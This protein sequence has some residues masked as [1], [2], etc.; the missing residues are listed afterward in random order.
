M[1]ST[2][3]AQQK[4]MCM[5][6]A[7]R[8]GKLNKSELKGAALDI[9]NSDMTDKEIKDFMVLKESTNMTL[10]ES[11]LKSVKAGKYA[12]IDDWCKNNITN[13]NGYII[14]DD[15]TISDK[16]GAGIY[17]KNDCKDIP[18]YIKFNTIE[19][20]FAIGPCINSLTKDQLP[21]STGFLTLFSNVEEL[22]VDNITTKYGMNILNIAYKPNALK[23]VKKFNIG[24]TDLYTPY[25]AS[26]ELDFSESKLRYKDLK[27]INVNAK[28][29][30]ITLFGT[31]AGKKL[32]KLYLEN[33]D[34]EKP[35]DFLKRECPNFINAIKYL[36]IDE[37]TFRKA[38]GNFYV[39][40]NQ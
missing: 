14:N 17:I 5:A 19:G 39:T 25:S 36:I 33:K 4:A 7:A 2:S 34:N 35:I 30:I 28:N 40:E 27:N 29:I 12:L 8:K 24:V 31:P 21:K 22:N 32:S 20:H 37:Y 11:I 15:L 18:S 6:Y 26:S 23:K 16:N 9:Y 3:K 1:P 38:D 13:E 10:K